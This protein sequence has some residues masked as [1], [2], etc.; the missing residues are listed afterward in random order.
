[1]LDNPED[2]G[3]LAYLAD[4]ARQ[5]GADVEILAIE[6]IGRTPPGVFVDAADAP[7]ET[8]VQ[9][10][11]VG[12]D[13]SRRIRRVASGRV[14]A[15]DRAALEGD[16]VQQGNLAAAVGDVSA[17]SQPAA[18]L[19]RRRSQ[20]R[21]TRALLCAKPLYSREG[22]NVEIVV[23][24]KVVEKPMTVPMAASRR[25]CKRWRRCRFSTATM[26]CLAPGLRPAHR[27]AFRCARI[28]ARLR[29]TRRVSCPTPLCEDGS[30][31]EAGRLPPSGQ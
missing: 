7:I 26:R 14:D 13:V 28:T 9:A 10:L 27:P 30:A 15:M 29:R 16:P 1:M 6:T 2:A 12:M 24:G 11:S 22:A 20:A 21:R 17:P 8:R 3:T 31:W 4:T 19:F 18:G 5:A 25:C 23:D